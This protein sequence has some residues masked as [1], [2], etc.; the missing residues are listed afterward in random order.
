MNNYDAEQIPSGGLTGYKLR[1]ADQL[2]ATIYLEQTEQVKG[3]IT[4]CSFGATWT[5]FFDGATPS[6]PEFLMGLVSNPEYLMDRF[7]PTK[8]Y[9]HD[10]LIRALL[11]QHSAL[12]GQIDQDILIGM[13][14]ELNELAELDFSRED[15]ISSMLGNKAQFPQIVG[16]IENLSDLI[17]GAMGYSKPLER[18]MREVY[19]LFVEKLTA[20]VEEEAQAG[21]RKLLNTS[22]DDLYLSVRAYNCLKGGKINTLEDLVQKTRED[23]LRLRLFGANSLYQVESLLAEKGLSLG[24]D[25]SKYA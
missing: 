6:F 14:A 22:I 21:A 11:L 10:R 5:T 8:T 2:I 18:F 15:Q 20:Q 19:P 16:N 3:R 1:N 24:M 12:F 4:V 13:K 23:L 9:H 7:E 17:D 25:L